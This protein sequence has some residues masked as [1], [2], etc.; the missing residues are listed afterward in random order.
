[1]LYSQVLDT[2]RPLDGA[3]TAEIPDAWTQGRTIFGGVQA[4][5]ALRAMRDLVPQTVPLRVL[6][7]T[8]IAPVPAGRLHIEASVLRSGKSVTHVEARIVDQGKS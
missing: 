5:L 4:A 7:T 1:M 2:V 3:W 8:F 6:Q